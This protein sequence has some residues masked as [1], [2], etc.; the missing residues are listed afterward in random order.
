MSTS[1]LLLQEMDVLSGRGKP[2]EQ[3]TANVIF[4]ALIDEFVDDYAEAKRSEKHEVI[5]DIIQ[6]TRTL[7]MRFVKIANNG[8]C[9]ELSALET[10]KKVRFLFF[11][12]LVEKA[13]E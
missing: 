13:N 8:V 7:D 9:R 6:Q 1:R 3:R 4:R 5:H 2:T 10:K 12:S 11:A